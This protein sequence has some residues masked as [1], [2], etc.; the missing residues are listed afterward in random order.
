MGRAF[1]IAV[2]SPSVLVSVN[3]ELHGQVQRCV[4]TVFFLIEIGRQGSWIASCR[5][6]S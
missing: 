5:S 3:K 2:V 6:V 4:L 1:C